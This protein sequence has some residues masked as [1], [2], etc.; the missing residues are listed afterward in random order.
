[1][2]AGIVLAHH[3]SF[4]ARNVAHFRDIYAA[5]VNGWAACSCPNVLSYEHRRHT[6]LGGFCPQFLKKFRTTQ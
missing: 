6:V 1:M 3:A 4:A 2:I 5:V